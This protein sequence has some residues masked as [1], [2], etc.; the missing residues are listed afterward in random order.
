MTSESWHGRPGREKN[1]MILASVFLPTHISFVP[2]MVMLIR[3]HILYIWS[4][5][6]ITFPSSHGPRRLH[7]SRPPF[8]L[9]HKMGMT[10]RLQ[11]GFFLGEM[12]E[13]IP[14]GGRKQG[15]ALIGCQ[16][17]RIAAF[18]YTTIATLELILPRMSK[19]SSQNGLW[20]IPVL[21]LVN[22]FTQKWFQR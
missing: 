5:I 1:V 7:Y 16:W 20:E 14:K 10:I 17:V 13:N 19:E 2:P 21:P 6:W 12:K 15:L 4:Y 9:I 8:F 22:Q 3:S 18:F 11:I